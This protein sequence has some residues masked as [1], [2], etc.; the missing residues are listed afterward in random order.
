MNMRGPS[1]LASTASTAINGRVCA[2]PRARK[3]ILGSGVGE[4]RS[5]LPLPLH[6]TAVRL[7]FTYLFAYLQCHVYPVQR[8]LHLRRSPIETPSRRDFERFGA[9]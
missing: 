8:L 7:C 2:T 6:T 1:S 5:P 9:L 3:I 4:L